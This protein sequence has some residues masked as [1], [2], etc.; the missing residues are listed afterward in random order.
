MPRTTSAPPSRAPLVAAAAVA[1]LAAL[2]AVALLAGRGDGGAPAAGDGQPL[3]M[4][5]VHGLGVD[6][7]DGALVAGTH[8]GAFRGSA[9]TAAPSAIVES[10][11]GGRTFRP[12]YAG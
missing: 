3:G 7:A 9:R 1:V 6:P 12:R 2:L 10:A 4:A 11:D 5:H 8:F